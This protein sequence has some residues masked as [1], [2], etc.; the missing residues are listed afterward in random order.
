MSENQLT[1]EQVAANKAAE[2][3]AKA[4]EKAR[5][6]AEK[7]VAKELAAAEKKAEKE[8]AK[9]AKEAE[10]AAKAAERQAAKEAKAAEKAAK[11]AVKMPEQNGVRRPRPGGLCAKA[12]EIADS[13][14]QKLGS[15]AP[16]ADVLEV[17]IAE[18]LNPGNVK[19]EY[20]RWRKFHGVTGRIVRSKADTAAE[21]PAETPAA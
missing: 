13:I 7:K 18:G 14:S 1:P 3:A 11:A 15:P 6:A 19:A 9:A 10:K 8:A 2:Q 4:E 21:T 16:V 12:W 17:A 5:I 20:A